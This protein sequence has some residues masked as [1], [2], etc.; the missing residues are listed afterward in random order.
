[1]GVGQGIAFGPTLWFLISSKMIKQMKQKG[2]GADMMS[3]LSLSLI[4][5]VCFA[6]VDDTNLI[7]SLPSRTTTGEQMIQEF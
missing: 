1:M 5:I 3:S 2:H 7:S 4:S 6:F